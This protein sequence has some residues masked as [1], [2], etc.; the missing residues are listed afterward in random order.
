M[1]L[2]TKLQEL[3]TLALCVADGQIRFGLPIRG[4]DDVGGLVDTAL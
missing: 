3:V 4:A 2:E 1:T